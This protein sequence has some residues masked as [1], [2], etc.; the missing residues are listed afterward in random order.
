MYFV[1]NLFMAYDGFTTAAVTAEGGMCGTYVRTRE[2]GKEGTLTIRA[3]GME[4][5]K[6]V[7]K[8]HKG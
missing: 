8:I 3:E 7:F 5:Q 4:D 2:N 6:I 1:Y